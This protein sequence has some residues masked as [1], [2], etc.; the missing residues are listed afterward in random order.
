MAQFYVSHC[1]LFEEKQ[2]IRAT[3]PLKWTMLS[4]PQIEV[5]FSNHAS[6]CQCAPNEILTWK[7]SLVFLIF[8][9]AKN[10]PVHITF[11]LSVWLAVY[12]KCFDI[13]HS[14]YAVLSCMLYCPVWLPEELLLMVNHNIKPFLTKILFFK[15]N[16]FLF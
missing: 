4:L 8:N 16:F 5:T 2:V 11:C 13:L 3:P 12:L 9:Q 14:V 10:I 6:C 15:F 1:T 7:P